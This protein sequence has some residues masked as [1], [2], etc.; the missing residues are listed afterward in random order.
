MKQRIWSLF[1]ITAWQSNYVISED[2]SCSGVTGLARLSATGLQR[3]ALLVTYSLP[4][5]SRQCVDHVHVCWESSEARHRSCADQD[6]ASEPRLY[7]TGLQ[8]GSCYTVSAAPVAADG[9]RY[10]TSVVAGRTFKCDVE[11]VTNITVAEGADVRQATV[12]WSSPPQN[13]KCADYQLV[14]CS[15]AGTGETVLA[16]TVPVA[17]TSLEI[18]GLEPCV[19]YTLAI[20][21]V[22]WNPLL[23]APATARFRTPS[24]VTSLSGLVVTGLSPSA[25]RVSYTIPQVSSL[26][27]H[28]FAICWAHR[29]TSSICTTRRGHSGTTVEVTGLA[30]STNY[31]VTVT[32]VAP[33]GTRYQ[34]VSAVGAT[35]A[36]P[37][38]PL[39][40]AEALDLG[41]GLFYVF[42]NYDNATRRLVN[43]TSVCVF[44]A[45]GSGSDRDCSSTSG[46][47]C[48]A[49]LGSRAL[50]CTRYSA[51][52]TAYL[53]SNQTASRTVNFTSGAAEVSDV[54][55]KKSSKG[56]DVTVSWTSPKRNALCVSY[57]SVTIIRVRDDAVVGTQI[58]SKE[59]NEVLFKD[60]ELCV[61]YQAVVQ[62]RTRDPKLPRATSKH[63]HLPSNVTS[64]AA[65]TV[66]SPRQDS[67]LVSYQLPPVSARCVG[68][69]LV[70]WVTSEGNTTCSSE[71]GPASSSVLVSHLSPCSNY[72]VQVT[73]VAPDGRRY[74]STTT[75]GHTSQSGD[76]CAGG[77]AGL[78]GRLCTVILLQALLLISSRN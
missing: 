55:V 54:S 63:F 29:G 28:H 66:T 71:E 40:D 57:Q 23:P 32:P 35:S 51:L 41:S 45:R 22:N 13:L 9:R 4:P 59:D 2:D 7:V 26:C 56:S 52:V 11:T 34:S 16:E 75:L 47:E 1:L 50:P 58:L 24:N 19:N 78:K 15:V 61:R 27:V 12:K 46:D 30:A 60:L 72:T 6:P 38:D 3:D 39:A 37:T 64:V 31:T 21:P 43:H 67:L 73:P 48:V 33:D 17:N 14:N 62:P 42:F 76:S 18:S 69:V 25:L 20:Q 49:A 53:T 8:A 77:K 68:A 5:A 10:R 74:D 65:V 36:A 44:E 70:C